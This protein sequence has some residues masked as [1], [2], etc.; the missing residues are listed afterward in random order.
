M[1]EYIPWQHETFKKFLKEDYEF[2]VF[3][4]AENEE[5]NNQTYAICNSLGIECLDVPQIIHSFHYLRREM[6][7]PEFRARSS[8]TI[9]YMLDMVGFDYPGI[10]MII[11]SDMF[12]CRETNIKNLMQNNEIVANKQSREGENGPV[13]YM[14]PSLMVFDMEK[15][16]DKRKLNFNL[17]II[18]GTATD[19]GGYTHFYLTQ[20]PQVK[21]RQ[22]NITY[23][24][25]INLKDNKID[26]GTCDY[27]LSHNKFL[28]ILIDNKFD[29]EF[30]DDFSFAHFKA[31]S[32]WYNKDPSWVQSKAD[33][34]FAALQ[35][36]LNE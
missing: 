24:G 26:R 16:K 6:P 8:E 13:E 15:L 23:A 17:G 33:L 11:D 1:P 32:N 29:Y 19:S 2:V 18:D 10:V 22:L 7:V 3:N 35:E 20:Y 14:L 31:G 27:I 30:F 21:W 5:V 34:F 12:L 28:R 25:G 4:D 36:L 9:Q